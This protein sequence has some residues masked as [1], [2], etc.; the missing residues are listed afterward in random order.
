MAK[1][2]RGI[3]LKNQK[4]LVFYTQYQLVEDLIQSSSTNTSLVTM[5]SDPTIHPTQVLF[6][7]RSSSGLES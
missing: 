4:S 7:P 3:G 5:A 1:T 6:L 2:T